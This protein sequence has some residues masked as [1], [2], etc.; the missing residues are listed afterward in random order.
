MREGT[1]GGRKRA[2]GRREGESREKKE[3]YTYAKEGKREQ[4]RNE[5]H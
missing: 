5:K 3:E 2:E 1:E 4:E